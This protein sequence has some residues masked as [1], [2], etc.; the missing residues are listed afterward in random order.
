M[1]GGNARAQSPKTK[2]QGLSPRGRGKHEKEA[3]AK[4][5][6]RSIPAWAGETLNRVSVVRISEV[7]PRVGGGNLADARSAF[8]PIGLSPR[9]RGKRG[10]PVW[11]Y[12]A[13]RSIPAWAGETLLDCA[14]AVKRKVYPRVGGGNRTRAVWSEIGY[15]LSPRGRGKPYRSA[16]KKQKAGSIPAWAG[17]TAWRVQALPEVGV[18]PRVGG[19]NHISALTRMGVQGLSPR[20]R[21]K[22]LPAGTTRNRQGSIPAWAGETRHRR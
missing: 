4:L 21:G 16:N 2:S 17:E 9:G 15:G 22:L 1:G 11:H 6:G 13:L 19:G 12:C 18:Y 14:C 20:G 10:R 7:Y 3:E 8:V 5:V